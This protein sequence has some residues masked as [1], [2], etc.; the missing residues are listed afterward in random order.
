MAA[1]LTQSVIQED[2]A[3]ECATEAMKWEEQVIQCI[4]QAEEDAI[5]A[6]ERPLQAQLQKSQAQHKNSKLV[7]KIIKLQKDLTAA[8]QGLAHYKQLEDDKWYW[9]NPAFAVFHKLQELISGIV[10]Y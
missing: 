7:I 4:A 9:N 10:L 2:Q 3:L 6:Q 8:L 5:K 1:T